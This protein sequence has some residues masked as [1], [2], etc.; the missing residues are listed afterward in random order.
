MNFVKWG[1][2]VVKGGKFSKQMST[3][4]SS[5]KFPVHKVILFLAVSV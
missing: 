1:E 4:F 3:S 2:R 5:R